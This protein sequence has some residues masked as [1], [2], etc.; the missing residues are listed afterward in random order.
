MAVGVVFFSVTW[1]GYPEVDG[2]PV[3]AQKK[4]RPRTM[5]ART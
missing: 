5:P 4:R 1:P 2:P 3:A